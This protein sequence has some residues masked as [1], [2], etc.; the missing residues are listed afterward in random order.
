MTSK[1]GLSHREQVKNFIAALGPALQ[2]VTAL[3]IKLPLQ[4]A[5][6]KK[7]TDPDVA[8]A[9]SPLAKACPRVQKLKVTGGVGP[10]LL[11]AFGTSSQDLNCLKTED[12]PFR[13]AERLGE[14]LPRVTSTT[15][16]VDNHE[17][18]DEY[19]NAVHSC[20]TL[21]SLDLS[22]RNVSEG[23]WAALPP[24]LRTLYAAGFEFGHGGFSSA[25]RLPNLRT[26]SSIDQTIELCAVAALLR[27]APGLEEL[28]IGDIWVPRK[29]DQI[30]DLVFVDKQLATGR[31]K[32]RE[33]SD[34]RITY[35][36]GVML[37]LRAMR[38]GW[39]FPVQLPDPLFAASLPVLENFSS[40]EVQTVD[41][42]L[43]A[44]LAQ[45]FPRLTSLVLREKMHSRHLPR[46]LVFTRLEKLY[47]QAKESIFSDF[48]LGAL[49]LRMPTLDYLG[50]LVT[51]NNIEEV[52]RSL[53]I[54]G[55]RV[56]LAHYWKQQGRGVAY[57]SSNL[58]LTDSRRGR[59]LR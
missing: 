7:I 41:Q 29:L 32:M 54:W 37:S 10:I 13:T 35:G 44:S 20:S 40:L 31:V 11:A 43:L 4:D 46:L 2:S 8:K 39:D 5:S 12:I 59:V 24:S 25:V 55:R 52:E 48:D 27:A 36:N 1:V 19:I 22:S 14:L 42:A 51:G 28:V 45:A 15:I 18:P 57:G 50:M 38:F 47:F 21:V 16:V 3:H 6:S 30:P 33:W 49:C 53:R 34:A 9:L 56:D 26:A 58:D 23:I 17:N